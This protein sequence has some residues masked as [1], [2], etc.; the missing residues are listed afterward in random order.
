MVFLIRRSRLK[1]KE[2]QWNDSRSQQQAQAISGKLHMNVVYIYHDTIDE[3]GHMESAVFSACDTAMEELKNLVRIITNEFGGIQ[4]L[5]TSDHGFLYTHSPLT[6]DDKVDKT[7]E[8][9]QDVEIGRRYAI[10]QIVQHVGPAALRLHYEC[11]QFRKC[12]VWNSPRNF[13]L[14]K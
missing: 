13:A 6:E 11:P 5:I 4:I 7:T 2:I 10:M 12:R 3:A 1:S 14:R 9:D 8:S